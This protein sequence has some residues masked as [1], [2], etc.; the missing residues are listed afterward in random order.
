VH[1][2]ALGSDEVEALA[3]AWSAGPTG[4]TPGPAAW[5][6]LSPAFLARATPDEAALAA[7]GLIARNGARLGLALGSTDDC[8]AGTPDPVFE[9]VA[10]AAE[11]AR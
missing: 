2:L 5:G 10:C 11:E 7:A 9:A 8:V 3:A 1:G 6:G 4:S